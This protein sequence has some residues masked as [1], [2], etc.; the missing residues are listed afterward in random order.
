MTNSHEHKCEASIYVDLRD[1][2][3][4]YEEFCNREATYYATT[5]LTDKDERMDMYL[6]DYHYRY[7]K[8][9]WNMEQ[10]KEALSKNGKN[11][12]SI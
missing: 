4:M 1:G 2:G 12:N 10:L 8:Q 6:C 9:Y 11:D 5:S 7:N 3:Y